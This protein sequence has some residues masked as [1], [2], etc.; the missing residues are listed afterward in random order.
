[1]RAQNLTRRLAATP[2]YLARAKKNLDNPPRAFTQTAI[3]QGRG[4]LEFLREVV[5][6]FAK[7][8][9]PKVRVKLI[10]TFLKSPEEMYYM[11]G[12]DGQYVVI[13]PSQELVVVRMGFSPGMGARQLLSFIAPLI[14]ALPD[15]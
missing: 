7:T 9:P 12:Y 15:G 3:L 5:P 4:T 11:S 10:K 6:A 2:A 13:I 8:V 14:H 1:V